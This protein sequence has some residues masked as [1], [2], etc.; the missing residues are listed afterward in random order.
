V[1]LY[2]ST[3]ND[4]PTLAP[5]W[6]AWKLFTVGDYLARAYRFRMDVAR[7]PLPTQQVAFSRLAITVDV[8][9]RVEGDNLV[10]VGTSGLAITFAAPFYSTPAIAITADSMATGD[11]YTLSGKSASGFFVQFF[12][13]GGTPIAKTMDWIAKGF[14][15]KV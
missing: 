8:P 2:I 13:S 5:S 14:G 7:G 9:D 10:S 15:Y 6:S 3:T 4:D 12:N 1:R 11:Y